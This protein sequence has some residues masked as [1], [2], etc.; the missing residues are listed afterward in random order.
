MTEGMSA[1]AQS[2]RSGWSY[3][4][5]E[6]VRA[7]DGASTVV[8]RAVDGCVELVSEN[9][10]V[11]VRARPGDGRWNIEGWA[12]P[13]G[14][15]AELL[16]AVAVATVEPSATFDVRPGDEIH[17]PFD[18][19]GRVD[20]GVEVWALR[21]AIRDVRSMYD[22]ARFA[23]L[24][25]GAVLQEYGGAV[26]F[27]A[28]GSWHGHP[29]YFRYRNGQASLSLTA[30]GRN[31]VGNPHWSGAVDFGDPIQG[32]LTFEEFLHLF[33]RCARELTRSEFVFEFAPVGAPDMRRL[34]REAMAETR[35]K[36]FRPGERP[37]R[38]AM[39]AAH[40]AYPPVVIRAY[41]LREARIK[42]GLE[43]ERTGIQYMLEPLTPDDR[44][45]PERMPP[46]IPTTP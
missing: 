33:G 26:P 10:G 1:A 19:N 21:G 34:Q 38:D 9:A 13:R 28:E 3:D 2:P 25:P 5:D 20:S 29:F 22:S 12:V 40:Q 11:A 7:W 36:G 27:Q 6:I 8:V 18:L 46:F 42:L 24:F 37:A 31:P 43:E 41:D 44:V 23:A 16:L 39:R 30:E 45:W 14:D 15:G 35:E 32:I 17:N 4:P